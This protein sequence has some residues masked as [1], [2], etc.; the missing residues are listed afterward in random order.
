[1]P[2]ASGLPFSHSQGNTKEE[3][4]ENIKQAIQ[5]YIESLRKDEEAIP[6]DIASLVEIA[7]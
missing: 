6:E 2:G 7:A 4:L 1:L 3:A 5:C